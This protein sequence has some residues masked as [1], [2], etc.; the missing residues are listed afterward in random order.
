MLERAVVQRIIT[1]EQAEIIKAAQI[2][3]RDVIMVD[4]FSADFKKHFD[5]VT[6]P[7]RKDAESVST[8][9]GNVS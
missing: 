2:A 1:P 4:E 9:K 6:E 3:R 8:T 7:L 5:P